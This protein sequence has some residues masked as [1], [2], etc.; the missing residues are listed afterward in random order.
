MVS[1]WLRRGKPPSSKRAKGSDV[2]CEFNVGEVLAMSM[3][4]AH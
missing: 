3:G 2:Y 4:A 1:D